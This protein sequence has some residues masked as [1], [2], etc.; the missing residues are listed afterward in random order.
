MGKRRRKRA[1]EAAPRGPAVVNGKRLTS[2]QRERLA[3]AEALAA[4]SWRDRQRAVSIIREVEAEIAAA[5][6]GTAVER[7]IEDTLERARA[8]G[9]AFEVETVDVGEWRRN[10]MGGLARRDGQPILD[11]Q[12][13]RRASRVDGLASLHKAGALSDGEKQIGDAYR[14]VLDRAMPPVSVSGYGSTQAG[15]KDVG[16]ML[17][18]VAEAGSALAI[19]S[20]IHRRVGDAKAVAVLEAVAGRGATIRS[21]GAGGDLNAANLRRL[22]AALHAAKCEFESLN[23]ARRTKALAREEH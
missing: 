12:T 15:F 17:V 14:L 18:S 6:A 11:V 16:H 22:K 1:I 8:R 4:G 2:T 10:E 23:E 5:R 20:A 3:E 19:I 21:L 7:G 9:E 13:V